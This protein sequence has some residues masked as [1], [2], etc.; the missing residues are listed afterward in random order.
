M[1][2]EIST[3]VNRGR[4]EEVWQRL[5]SFLDLTVSEFMTIQERLLS[6]QLQIVGRSKL[7]Q[8]VMGDQIPDSV[9]AFRRRVRLT[10]YADYAPYLD[11]HRED[12]LAEKPVAWAHTSGRSGQFKWAPYTARAFKNLGEGM[13][14][15][16]LLSNARAGRS[17]YPAGRRVRIQHPCPAVHERSCDPQPGRVI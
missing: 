5:C 6:E 2:T 12:V 15:A 3:L 1:A 17:T 10:T 13:L 4:S 9:E 11:E 16:A 8:I 7:S 14:S